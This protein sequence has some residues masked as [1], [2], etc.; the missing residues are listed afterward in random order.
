M[1]VFKEKTWESAWKISS[2]SANARTVDTKRVWR[3]EWKRNISKEQNRKRDKNCPRSGNLAPTL[4]S[5]R[6][7]A[8]T[9]YSKLQS[10]FGGEDCTFLCFVLTLAFSLY[11]EGVNKALEAQSQ[12]QSPGDSNGNG[13]D[14]SPEGVT[15]TMIDR[16]Q[17]LKLNVPDWD[18]ENSRQ[19]QAHRMRHMMSMANIHKV[20]RFSLNT[21]TSG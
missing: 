5:S 16:L 11:K 17:N 1:K 15:K 20:L 19:G 12:S 21:P 8:R 9:A 2:C 3:R 14:T 4:I 18:T 7:R 13:N 10:R 6:T